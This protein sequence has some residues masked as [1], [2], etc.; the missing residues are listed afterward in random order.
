MKHNSFKSIA[1]MYLIAILSMML[2]HGCGSGS[3]SSET[4]EPAPLVTS[5]KITSKPITEAVANEEYFYQIDIRGAGDVTVVKPQWMWFDD[6]LLTLSGTPKES[7]V[8]LSS[9]TINVSNDNNET[10]TQSF[11][12]EVKQMYLE[13]NEN[14]VFLPSYEVGYKSTSIPIEFIVSDYD[15]ISEY[16]IIFTRAVN[17]IPVDYTFGRAMI[18][19]THNVAIISADVTIPE[20]DSNLTQNHTISAMY[21]KNGI[22]ELIYA[23]NIKQSIFIPE[24]VVHEISVNMEN[25]NG[26]YTLVTDENGVVT[27]TPNESFMRE[28]CDATGGTWNQSVMICVP[29]EESIEY[30]EVLA[31][32][33]NP[34]SPNQWSFILHACYAELEPQRTTEDICNILGVDYNSTSRTCTLK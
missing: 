10:D 17:G 7:D 28:S 2:L 22:E 12:V 19:V 30:E 16:T 15:N 23:V 6:I 3:S 18:D 13:L 29:P 34:Y 1:I 25:A 20:N 4:T 14:L 24:V 8:G 32:V 33:N 5:L 26:G 27:I 31:C 9:V 21:L 11:Y